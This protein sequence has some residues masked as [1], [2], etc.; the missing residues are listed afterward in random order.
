MKHVVSTLNYLLPNF[1]KMS[2]KFVSVIINCRNSEKFLKS[3]LES[4]LNQSYKD[5]EVLIIDNNSTDKTKEI[6]QSFSDKR[7][8]YYYLKNFK[9]W[10]CKKFCADRS[11]GELIAFIDSDDLWHRDKLSKIVCKFS[12]KIGLVYSDVEYF[13][14]LNP[15]DFT[16][17]EK[18]TG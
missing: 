1:L 18:Y 9:P 10:K 8:S 12:E 4:V 11:K 14:K 17:I 3:C 16:V 13:K 6:I 5:F 15:L 7:I 2:E